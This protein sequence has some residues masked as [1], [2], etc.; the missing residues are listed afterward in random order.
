MIVIAVLL[1]LIP[2]VTA[3]VA[4][5]RMWRGSRKRRLW[6]AGLVPAGSAVVVALGVLLWGA[7]NVFDRQPASGCSA[8]TTYCPAGGMPGVRPDSPIATFGL[9]IAATALATLVVAVVLAMVTGI[10]EA[11]RAGRASAGDG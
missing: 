10:T 9:W 2:P 4:W 7:G 11:I 6:F 5:A 3:V 1:G 8:Q